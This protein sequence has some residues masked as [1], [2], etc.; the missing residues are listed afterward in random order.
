MQHKEARV[1]GLFLYLNA[2]LFRYFSQL[3]FLQSPAACF[4]VQHKSVQAS[5]G[6][7]PKNVPSWPTIFCLQIPCSMIIWEAMFLFSRTR[8]ILAFPYSFPS[9]TFH[10]LTAFY[11]HPPKMIFPFLPLLPSSNIYGYL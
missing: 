1:N 4:V 5:S 7:A 11:W 10:A 2:A 3:N 8:L 6:S 9:R